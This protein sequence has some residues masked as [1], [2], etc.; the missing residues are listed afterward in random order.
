MIYIMIIFGCV[1]LYLLD[2]KQGKRERGVCGTRPVLT[3]VHLSY[4]CALTVC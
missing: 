1:F 3:H 4:V 2:R